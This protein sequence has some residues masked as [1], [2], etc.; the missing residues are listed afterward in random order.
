MLYGD[1]P[2]EYVLNNFLVSRMSTIL[3]LACC[4]ARRSE[5]VTSFLPDALTHCPRSQCV[6]R[7]VSAAD[8]MLRIFASM[9]TLFD[10]S[11][12]QAEEC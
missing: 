2:L 9:R 5:S 11:N 1:E 12:S 6:F 8:S 4:L 10:E 7:R 3:L